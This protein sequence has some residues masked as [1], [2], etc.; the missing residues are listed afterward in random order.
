M[1]WIYY[2][3][4]IKKKHIMKNILKL[5]LLFMVFA[6]STLSSCDKDCDRPDVGIYE[7]V[8]PFELSP[9]QDVFHIG[10]TITISCFLENPIYE[11][12]T[13][14]EYQLDDFKFYLTTSIYDM[15]TSIIDFK[16]FEH[17]EL[18][19]D[20]NYWHNIFRFSNGES[21]LL[22][23]FIFKDNEYSINYKLIPKK[24][25]HFLL[26]QGSDINYRGG[27]QAFALQCRNTEIDA[28]VYM[29]KRGDNN[30]QLINEAKNS[31]YKDWSPHK[32]RYLDTG[33]YCFKV[34]D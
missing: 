19:I 31:Y 13:K 8:L 5:S 17:F 23:Q 9:A 14:N 7:F 30:F 26:F 24:K 2:L 21:D 1:K 25:G 4:V 27:K 11:R 12:K 33:G 3:I 15:D 16:Y 6:I 22:S 18:L 20:N 28:K 34:V 32:E 29:N 10:D